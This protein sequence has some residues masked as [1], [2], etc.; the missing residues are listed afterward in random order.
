MIYI[1]FQ[2]VTEELIFESIENTS[3]NGSDYGSCEE[4]DPV[5]EEVIVFPFM[6]ASLFIISIHI[7]IRCDATQ[8]RKAF[9]FSICLRTPAQPNAQVNGH[10]YMNADIH[11]KFQPGLDEQMLSVYS[12]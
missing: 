8:S 11:Y 4:K 2:D 5:Y 1:S 12:S 3:G 9:V 10:F 6:K 7:D